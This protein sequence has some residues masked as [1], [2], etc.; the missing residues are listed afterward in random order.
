[1]RY[2]FIFVVLWCANAHAQATRIEGV[3]S[4]PVTI[5]DFG[6][7]SDA[8]E[9][10]Q[11]AANAGQT[12]DARESDLIAC[13]MAISRTG[14]NN[15]NL[16]STYLNRGIIYTALGQFEQAQADYL[17]SESLHPDNAA[18]YLNMGNLSLLMGDLDLALAH[19]ENASN[20]GLTETHVLAAN[21]GMALFLL[22][23]EQEAEAEYEKALEIMPGWKTASDQ[24]EL[25]RSWSEEAGHNR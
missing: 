23:R 14:M 11:S 19:Y 8:K 1:M 7:S 4:Q 25:L 24:R 22:G 9:C 13:D 12:A 3:E 21:R 18:L 20:L 5:I 6:M 17:R 16:A 10:M 2:S 15:A